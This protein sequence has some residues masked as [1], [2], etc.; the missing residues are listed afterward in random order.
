[1]CKPSPSSPNRALKCRSLVIRG[2]VSRSR[3]FSQCTVT[4]FYID[5]SGFSDRQIPA[6]LKRSGAGTR[7]PALCQEHDI[8]RATL[9]QVAGEVREHVR[10]GVRVST[11][12]EL[13]GHKD[14]K[15]TMI[16]AHALN[17]GGRGVRSPLDRG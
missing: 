5:R 7:V 8:S 14:V 2:A 15:T 1:M 3:L 12:Q 13:L 17:R 10:V 11:V 4:S 6:I 9:L 16:Y